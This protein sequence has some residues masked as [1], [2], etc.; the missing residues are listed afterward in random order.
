MHYLIDSF[1]YQNNLR[2]LPPEPKVIFAIALF[3]LS[4]FASSFLQIIIAIWLIIWVVI[5]AKIP[6]KFYLKLLLIPIGFYLLS[7]PALLIEIDWINHINNSNLDVIISLKL[8]NIYFYMSNQGIKQAIIILSRTLALTSCLYFMLLTVPFVELV[9]IL[10]KWGFPS[11]FTELLTL[12]YRFIFLL[13][14]TTEELLTAQKSRLGYSNF[15]SSFKSLSILIGQILRKTLENYRQ[16]A[17][18]LQSRGYQGKLT[19]CHSRHY[20]KNWRYLIEA[21]AGYLVLLII[22]IQENVNG[23]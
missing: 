23:I 5:Y 9:R 3:T 8:K 15:K 19:V 20:Q 1:S 22:F 17:L 21:I 6:C 16:I 4:Y 12:M 2:T 13:T 14:V 10:D 11:L 18:G 7:L